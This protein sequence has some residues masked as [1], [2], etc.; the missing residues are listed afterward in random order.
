MQHSPRQTSTSDDCGTVCSSLVTVWM[1]VSIC[2]FL[3]SLRTTSLSSSSI[4]CQTKGIWE[5]SP[6][7]RSV[8]FCISS[9][10]LTSHLH[11]KQTAVKKAFCLLQVVQLLCRRWSVQVTSG[12]LNGVIRSLLPSSLLNVSSFGLIF[13]TFLKQLWGDR[14]QKSVTMCSQNIGGSRNPDTMLEIAK[15][16]CELR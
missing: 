11:F 2:R 13:I 8:M 7:A 16:D 15:N 9:W 5:A 1:K 6:K 14:L 4:C 12:Q 10:I 3:R